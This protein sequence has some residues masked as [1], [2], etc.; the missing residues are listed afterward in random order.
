MVVGSN[1][2]RLSNSADG[3][4]LPITSRIPHRYP[5]AARQV[6]DVTCTATFLILL[7]PIMSRRRRWRSVMCEK[8]QRWRTKHSIKIHTTYIPKSMREHDADD[9]SYS[10]EDFIDDRAVET[11]NDKDD[12]PD[13]DEDSSEAQLRRLDEQDFDMRAILGGHDERLRADPEEPYR[14]PEHLV[15]LSGAETPAR[16]E[17]DYPSDIQM[18]SRPT[19]PA[20]SWTPQPMSRAATPAYVPATTPAQQPAV[21]PDPDPVTAPSQLRQRTPLFLPGSRSAT[22]FEY[23]GPPLSRDTTPYPPFAS[24]RPLFLP[25]SR[26]PTPFMDDLTSYPPSSSSRPM[27]SR[28]PSPA[29]DSPPSKRRRVDSPPR[30]RSP[31]TA[32]RI[33]TTKRAV[34][35]F[36]DTAA[37]D[38]DEDIPEEDEDDEEETLS[39]AGFIDDD[40]PEDGLPNARPV[41]DE[42]SD[43]LHEASDEKIQQLVTHYEQNAGRYARDTMRER[44]HRSSGEKV[45]PDEIVAHIA[46]VVK[47]GENA[48]V[49]PGD[50]I[51]LTGA[52]NRGALAYVVSPT[53]VLVATAADPNHDKDQHVLLATAAA[54]LDADVDKRLFDDP[55]L[56]MDKRLLVGLASVDKATPLVNPDH[57][58]DKHAIVATAP[59]D[60]DDADA[61]SKQPADADVC[62]TDD[63]D[64]VTMPPPSKLPPDVC[65]KISFSQPLMRKKHPMLHPMRDEL[66]PFQRT[67]LRYLQ[68]ARF[69]GDTGFGLM[70]GDRVVCPVGKRGGLQG[71]IG[72]IVKKISGDSY[73]YRVKICDYFGTIPD[74]QKTPGDWFRVSTL[75]RHI[76]DP[77]PTVHLLDRVQVKYGRNCLDK[78]GRVVEISGPTL[79]VEL[80]EHTIGTLDFGLLEQNTLTGGWRFTIPTH[81]TIRLFLPGDLIRVVYGDSSGRR[82]F[83]VHIYPGGILEIF[84]DRERAGQEHVFLV[85]Q[86]DVEFVIL[87][88]N[89]AF[90]DYSTFEY[91]A[92]SEINPPTQPL[93]VP[94][95]VD[96]AAIQSEL[97]E[98]HKRFAQA[99]GDEQPGMKEYRQD[100]VAYVEKVTHPL[101]IKGIQQRDREADDRARRLMNTGKRYEG[102]EV[103]VVGK[104]PDKGTWGTVVG[105]HD[106]E[107][108]AKRM[109]AWTSANPDKDVY[110]R[111]W[112]DSRG[113]L[114]SI[115]THKG[116]II[117][118]I[119]VENLVMRRHDLSLKP[120]PLTRA[121]HLPSAPTKSEDTGE[122]MCI[123]ALKGKRVDVVLEGVN[124]VALQTHRI[125]KTSPKI[126]ALE[127]KVGYFLLVNAVDPKSIDKKKVQ[128]YGLGV[129]HGIAPMCIKPRRFSDDGTT[130]IDAFKE[131]VVIVGPDIQGDIVAKGC[132]AQTRPHTEHTHSGG[133]VEV[134]LESGGLKFHHYSSLCMARN[135]HIDTTDNAFPSHT[136][137]N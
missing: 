31:P 77:G 8:A 30:S 125:F 101:T 127:G 55:D 69:W 35:D 104:H 110:A 40:V 21:L 87:K 83:I 124:S 65:T 10:V 46:G 128:V 38:S 61:P 71:W 96:L 52:P 91:T 14:I 27:T 117:Q 107:A 112:W 114:V 41:F 36:F 20:P 75:A 48:T 23:F 136:A 42:D 54:D 1:G 33:S 67:R 103:E 19:S 17:D 94:Q 108:R 47:S 90:S 44:G 25:D 39:D 135:I 58:A 9:V 105:D 56:A 137:R 22:P 84:D 106:S 29:P 60:P 133:I 70:E 68:S 3:T 132:Y 49:L 26:G 2:R 63:V 34:L 78:I 16:G 45:E 62:T 123:P 79:S 37:G 74:T 12:A 76:L 115:R 64:E 116:S 85:R 28:P 113:I 81:H 32:A 11:D 82:G 102:R 80:P 6:T 66:A 5:S 15:Q 122:W 111:R 97:G 95:P 57:D 119:P 92:R 4:E 89:A 131:R 73:Y 72:R 43:D 93:A 13:D 88:D 98:A 109:K 7:P 50:W 99:E 59:V 53:R 129:P 18:H 51:R 134:E 86:S 130:R 100:L 120:V 118:D 126:R 24:S 121:Y